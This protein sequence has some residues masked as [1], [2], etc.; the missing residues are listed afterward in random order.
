MFKGFFVDKDI[1]DLSVNYESVSTCRFICLN[2]QIFFEY[3]FYK[4]PHVG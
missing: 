3:T 2:N 4:M 1:H